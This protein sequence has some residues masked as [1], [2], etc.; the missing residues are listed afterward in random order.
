[1]SKPKEGNWGEWVGKAW[2][3]WCAGEHN[4]S[5]IAKALG[6]TRETVKNNLIKYSAARASEVA[7][8][9]P[10]ADYLGGLEYDLQEALRTY[11]G[12]PNPNAKVGALKLATQI[13]KEMAAARGVVVDRKAIEVTGAGGAPI[14]M[15]TGQRI[16][17]SGE[18]A[19]EIIK[20]HL[21]ETGED[22]A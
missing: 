19:M 20:F 8:I 2:A 18:A 14:Q 21:K 4:Y 11:R 22:G 7:D 12:S 16:E 13:R 15:E 5:A 9:N 1:M 3:M 6:V 17:L 10:T